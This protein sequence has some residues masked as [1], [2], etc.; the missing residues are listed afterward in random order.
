M[1]FF[2]FFA[3][4]DRFPVAPVELLVQFIIGNKLYALFDFAF[5]VNGLV[6]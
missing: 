1:E 5:H 4:H 6:F 2:F 3:L